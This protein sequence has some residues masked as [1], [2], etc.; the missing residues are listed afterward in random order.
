MTGKHISTFQVAS[1]DLRKGV[2]NAEKEVGELISY[3]HH[4]GGS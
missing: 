1:I 2:E 3:S 4:P